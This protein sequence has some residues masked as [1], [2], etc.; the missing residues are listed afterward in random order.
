MLENSN[1]REKA[2]G[3]TAVVPYMRHLS[4][5]L[6][7]IGAPTNVR[8]VFSAPKKLSNLCKATCPEKKR[9]KSC[10]INHKNKFVECAKQVVYIILLPCGHKYV[11]QTS[12][13]LNVRLHEHFRNV[14]NGHTGQLSEHCRKC[15]CTPTFNETRV[16]AKHKKASKKASKKPEK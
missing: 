9:E 3:R 5:G 1:T 15:K 12:Q 4:H 16:V 10:T 14:E 6:K 2:T 7:Q 11:G 13:C 8:V